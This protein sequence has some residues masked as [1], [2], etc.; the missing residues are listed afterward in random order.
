MF[1]I[2]CIKIASKNV[3]IKFHFQYSKYAYLSN[4]TLASIENRISSIDNSI[5]SHIPSKTPH[6]TQP[7]TP[8]PPSVSNEPHSH[9]LHSSPPTLPKHSNQPNPSANNTPEAEPV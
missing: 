7:Q 8:T 5:S 3:E 6:K 1:L 2:S 9:H 4:S